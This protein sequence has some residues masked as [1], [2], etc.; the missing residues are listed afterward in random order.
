MTITTVYTSLN[1]NMY[2]TEREALL[3]DF[4]VLK[5]DLERKVMFLTVFLSEDRF[6]EVRDAYLALLEKHREY[7]R[8][9]SQETKEDIP[10]LERTETI[11]Q[12][13][14][15]AAVRELKVA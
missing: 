9:V 2:A 8:H 7:R 13:V 3:A 4:H 5:H 6:R 15:L 14:D 11:G 12:F 10:T 1:G